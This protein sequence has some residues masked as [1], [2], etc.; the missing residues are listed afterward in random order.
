MVLDSSFLVAFHNER[1]SQHQPAQAL[2]DRFLAGEWGRGLLLEYAFL[3]VVTVLLVRR[4]LSTAVR[5]G[6]VLLDA[7]ELEFVPCSDFFPQTVASFSRQAETKLSLADVAPSVVAR[8]RADGRI[9]SFDREFSRI[10]DLRV[11]PAWLRIPTP[12]EE[13]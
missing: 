8:T 12:P 1:D 2:M 5:V 10:P 13:T 9:L 6:Q 4:D 11:F 3:E 7:Q